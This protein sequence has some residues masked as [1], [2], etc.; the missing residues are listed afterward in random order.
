MTLQYIVEALRS[1]SKREVVEP[2]PYKN[3]KNC[4][5]RYFT[6]WFGGRYYMFSLHDCN[7]VPSYAQIADWLEKGTIATDKS[8]NYSNKSDSWG[9]YETVYT[10]RGWI[11]TSV[12]DSES[13]T[14]Q[15]HNDHIRE[16]PPEQLIAKTLFGGKGIPLSSVSNSEKMRKIFNGNF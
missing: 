13:T 1:R 15:I 2:T 11:M 5:G 4:W 12:S 9:Y 6:L 3:K 7:D 10:D 8:G 16:V 14:Y